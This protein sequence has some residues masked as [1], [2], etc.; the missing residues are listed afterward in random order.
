[1]FD[2]YL[3][4]NF[5][6]HASNS[7]FNFTFNTL[8][9]YNEVKKIEYSLSFNNT[10]I[11]YL[12]RSETKKNYFTNNYVHLFIYGS[13][14]TN[15]NYRSLKNVN[16]YSL[17]A[18]D[19]FTLYS[20]F[21]EKLTNYIKGS[22]V[23]VICENDSVKL[24]SDRLNV[25]PLYYSLNED[26]LLISSSIKAILKSLSTNDEIDKTSL[27]QQL[28]F[29]YLLDDRT[30]YKNIKRI[31]PGSIYDFKDS[32]ISI[33]KY[34]GVEKL[35][36]E[37]LLPRN[38]SLDL[39]AQQ[40][41]E[42]V[43]LY[44]SDTNKVLV[45]LTGGFDG[46]TNLAMLR[47]EKENYLCYSYGMAGSRQITIPMEISK[48]LDI[49]YLPIYC[50][51]NFERK[52]VENGNKVIEF[53]NGQ[54]P[55]TQAVLPYAYSQL[56]QSSDVILTGL[57]GSEILRPLHN[58]GI[59]INDYSE[60]I[61]LSN[62][63]ENELQKVIDELSNL[64]Y[65]NN[66]IL[67][68]SQA[69][70]MHHFLRHY[71]D[72]FSGFDKIT[73]F[74]LF[75]I[76]EGIRKY[77]SQEIQSERVYVTNRFPYFDDD[78]IELV[79]KTTY[80]GMYNGFLGK[81]KFKRRK[82]QLLYAEIFRKFY[83]ELADIPLDRG[84]KPKDLLKLF[85]VNYFFIGK[86]VIKTKKYY[87]KFGNDTFNTPKWSLNYINAVRNNINMDLILGKGLESFKPLNN[88][89]LRL[90]FSHFLSIYSYLINA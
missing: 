83:P 34:W 13:I 48:K 29:D 62:T 57:F 31:K 12:E 23:I 55:F 58:L 40:L 56:S 21:K 27:T 20:E 74:F 86:E 6:D 17:S 15:N 24:I 63:P 85:P 90:K 73:R 89:H 65:L 41:F 26:V 14:F 46:R 37:N 88:E 11:K 7:K 42:N 75:I 81:N 10:I 8:S 32:S 76:E 87:A 5:S 33:K 38:Q 4:K 25:L 64:D 69:D 22:F 50:D 18:K 3:L 36:N 70:L 1:M 19:L 39:L 2:F 49:P 43:S 66:D 35:Y 71:I 44:T 72:R 59:I 53:S 47:K 51:D 54:A 67:K 16:P 45:S 9:Y 82:G 79:Y 52:Y 84:Y 30:F 77:F 61:F 68:Q 78:F 80:A 28:I 60:R